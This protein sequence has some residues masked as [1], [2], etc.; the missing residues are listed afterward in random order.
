VRASQHRALRPLFDVFFCSR[1]LIQT[2]SS[3]ADRS[4]YAERLD[5]ARTFSC[6]DSRTGSCLI[7]EQG[8]LGSVP[9]TAPLGRVH[10]L[11]GIQS[12]AA[13][14]Y[15]FVLLIQPGMTAAKPATGGLSL[16]IF[17]SLT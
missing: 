1:L 12:K 14:Y 16:L 2:L 4:R 13:D 15:C 3:A 6:L 10:V 9:A 11:L 8:I 7:Y 17:R 5:F